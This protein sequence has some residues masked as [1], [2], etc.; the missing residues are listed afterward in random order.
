[1]G[2]SRTH[3]SVKTSTYNKAKQIVK[4]YKKMGLIITM[5]D[6]LVMAKNEENNKNSIL[7]GFKI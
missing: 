5:E 4:R 3:I 7:G 6:A 2:E 1:M